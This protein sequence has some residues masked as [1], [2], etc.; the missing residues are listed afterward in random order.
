MK[1]GVSIGTRIML[2]RRNGPAS[3]SVTTMTIAKSA[4]IAPDVYHLCPFMTHSS[5]S[6]SARVCSVVGSEPETSGSVIEKQLR[7]S[8]SSS[9]ARKRSRCASV[10]CSARISMFPVSGAAQLN[11]IGAATGLRPICSQR[12]PYSQLVRPE[13]KRSSGRNRFQRPCSFA[14]AR[15]STRICG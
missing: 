6:S 3:G 5:P 7:V 14:L 15:V 9:G 11:D 12:I 13:P 1:P 10:P 2:A 4:P 8:P